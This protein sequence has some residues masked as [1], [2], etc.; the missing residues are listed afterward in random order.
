MK[1]GI[2]I[3]TY[4]LLTSSLFTACSNIRIL[5]GGKRSDLYRSGFLKQV[6]VVKGH[7]ARGNSDKAVQILNAMSTEELLPAERA[8]RKNLVGVILFSNGKYEEAISAF[9]GALVTSSI[10]EA[11]TSQVYLNLASSYFK[12]DFSEK[13]FIMTEKSDFKMLSNN[14]AKKYHFLKYKLSKQLG[15]DEHK[16][17]A[18]TRF[19][20]FEKSLNNFRDGVYFQ[21]LLDTFFNLDQTERAK[22]LERYEDEKLL[23]IG[24]LAYLNAEKLY[25]EGKK[26]SA[27]DFLKWIEEQYADVSEILLLV[28]KFEFRMD[29]YTKINSRSIGI[30]LPLSGKKKN[31][32][33]RAATG[34]ASALSRIK[35]MWKTEEAPFDLVFRDSKGSGAAGAFRVKELIE[36]YNVTA[37]IGGL[38][39]SEATK[40]YLEA[41]NR[42]VFFIS[43]SQIYLPRDQKDYLL[44]E[45]PGSIESQ[46]DEIFSSKMLNKFGRRTAI[47][48]P[49]SQRGNAYLNEFWRKA[50]E[51]KI[52]IS[53]IQ[54]FNEATKDF[55]EPVENLLGLKHPRERQEEIDLVTEI[56]SLEKKKSVRRIQ[57]LKPQI[58]FDWIFMPSYPKQASLLVPAFSY[59]DAFKINFIGGPSWGKS[60]ELTEES[61][62]LGKLFFVGDNVEQTDEG[63]IERFILKYKTRPG[64]IEMVSHDSLRIIGEIMRD[65]SFNT[66]DEFDIHLKSKKK[67][68]G[69]TGDWIQESGIWLKKMLPKVLRRGKVKKIFEE[70]HSFLNKTPVNSIYGII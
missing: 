48:Y 22:F 65:K 9:E 32:G 43:L 10:D 45:I 36:K 14:E 13:A 4:I 1:N 70:Q 5:G 30:V 2:F 49:N 12:L 21:E 40:E 25:Y 3:I 37:I 57:I 24:Y 64:F 35:T 51:S 41:R 29:N 33:K 44:L 62:K 67:L 63:F 17:D 58:D 56:Y 19:L 39:S 23:S 15:R 68:S 8:F 20:G 7:Y 34:I 42:G 27:R 46:L 18:L 28:Q 26:D 66:R 52:H 55:R 60:K 31:F 50:K 47:I 53:G 59:F 6:K 54:S 16:I 61:N 69:I 11:L 38:F